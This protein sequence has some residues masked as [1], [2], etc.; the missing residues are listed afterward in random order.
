MAYF[1]IMKKLSS[2]L[3][4]HYICRVCAM[5]IM[6]LF[7]RQ[8]DRI[9]EATVNWFKLG[10]T[11]CPFSLTVN[12]SFITWSTNDARI[13]FDSSGLLCLCSPLPALPLPLTPPPPLT[14][15]LPFPLPGAFIVVEQVFRRSCGLYSFQILIGELTNY[16]SGVWPSVVCVNGTLV[17]CLIVWVTLWQISVSYLEICMYCMYVFNC[18][19]CAKEDFV[20]RI[21]LIIE[22]TLWSLV[23]VFKIGLYIWF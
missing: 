13:S 2:I 1:S 17:C 3:H 21:L 4:F 14:L 9:T 16:Q 19:L 6:Y 8:N 20:F 10:C 18:K 23:S 7:S 22:G 11:C 15:P 12:S 5:L